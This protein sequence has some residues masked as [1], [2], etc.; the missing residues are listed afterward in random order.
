MATSLVLLG[1]YDGQLYFSFSNSM[2][3][4]LR[5]RSVLPSF[6]YPQGLTHAIVDKM[7]WPS[8]SIHMYVQYSYIF[9]DLVHIPM[10]MLTVLLN[11]FYI[12]FFLKS[13]T[14]RLSAYIMTSSISSVVF[15]ILPLMNLFPFFL[16]HIFQFI[17]DCQCPKS[18]FFF[19]CDR[20]SL[21]NP[22][23]PQ[24][25]NPLASAFQVLR[26]QACTTM[27]GPC[28]SHLVS[29]T[30]TIL[31]GTSV[32]TSSGTCEKCRIPDPAPGAFESDLHFNKLS[33]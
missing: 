1:L 15:I 30:Q 33:R 20:V 25:H 13:L 18:F 7:P 14:E 10:L 29:G 6:S 27:P 19:F 9:G 12:K 32:S 4:Y 5:I 2:M 16:N 11:L 28:H 31:Y 22:G 21:C 17:C 8:Q 23:W 24:I 3:S 26:L